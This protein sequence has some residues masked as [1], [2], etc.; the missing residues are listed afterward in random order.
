MERNFDMYRIDVL[1]LAAMLSLTSL[2]HADHWPNWRGPDNN[3][4]SKEKGLPTSWSETKNLA[5]K[6]PL[7]GK[8]SSTP[9]VWGDRI[10]LTGAENSDLVLWCVS[11]E[12][13]MLWKK[14]LAAAVRDV[15][16]KDEANEAS[17]SP[18]TDGKHV[19]AFVATGDVACFDFDGNEIWHFNAQKRYGKF[20][21]QHGIHVTPILHKDKLYFSL[22]HELGHWVIAIDKANGKDVWKVQRKSD[23]EGESKEAYASPVLWKNGNELNLV[24]LGADYTTGH[25]LSDGKELWRLGDL[26]PK[27]TYSKA[28]RIIASPVATEDRLY[29]PTARGGLMVALKQ[30]VE[31]EIKAGDKFEAW[32]IA[33]GSPDVP[34]P[35]IHDDLAYLMRENGVLIVLNAKTGEEHYNQRLSAER[36]RSSPVYADGKIYAVGRDSGTV[37]VIK[38]GPKYELLATNRINDEFSA[39][40]AI[41]GGRI[42]L[43]GFRALYGI[44]EGK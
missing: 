19:F 42:Y 37:S 6:L 24:V 23:A 28:L 36:Y 38:A 44:Q 2:A 39:S 13:K 25:R 32:R 1:A 15:I 31:G 3:G 35:L 7:P 43:R 5:W 10:F 14:K 8:G 26:N 33:K 27:K 9:I 29:V 22:L 17:A 4:V 20:K 30:G 21:I 40:P 16:K 34:S 11:T 12:G 41:S 18:S